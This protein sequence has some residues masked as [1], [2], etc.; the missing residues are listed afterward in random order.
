MTRKLINILLTLLILIATIGVSVS[1]HY[2]AGD[3]V[4][5]AINSHTNGCSDSGMPMDC[6]TDDTQ[7]YAIDDDYQLNLQTFHFQAPTVVLHRISEVINTDLIAFEL[8]N[9]DNTAPP[10]L[11]QDQDIFIRIQSFLL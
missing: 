4:E 7:L 6:C 9:E 2:C 1:K 8:Q 5:V 3:L 11:E 10:P